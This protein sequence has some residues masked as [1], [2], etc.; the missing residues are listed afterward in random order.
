MKKGKKKWFTVAL[1]ALLAGLTVAADQG[2]VPPLVGPV[3]EAVG[4]VLLPG[5]VAMFAS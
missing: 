3:V 2:I 1:A 4:G 5:P